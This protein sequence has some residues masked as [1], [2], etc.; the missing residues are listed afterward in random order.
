M[1]DSTFWHEIGPGP[2]VVD[3]ELVA[4]PTAVRRQASESAAD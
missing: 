1:G 3:L 2:T 4:D